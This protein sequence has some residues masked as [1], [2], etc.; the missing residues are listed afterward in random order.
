MKKLTQTLLS[1]TLSALGANSVYADQTS[2]VYGI[3]DRSS[4][5]FAL[6]HATVF[7]EPGK[8]IKDATLVIDNGL[9]ISVK[10]KG[11]VPA[12][13]TEVDLTSHLIY[14]G[15]I[16]PYSNY[17]FPKDKPKAPSADEG[18]K[19]TGDRKGGN[20]WNNAVHAEINWVDQF[21]PDTKTAKSF[22]KNGFTAVQT[23]K[24]D[25]IFQGQG[26]TVSLAKGLPNDLIYNSHA[27]HF[28]SFDKGSSKQEYPSSLMGSIALIRQTL[29]DSD[30]YE[31]AR[32]K[33]DNLNT[34]ELVEYNTALK[35]ISE[36][37]QTG[38]IFNADDYLSTMRADKLF[39]QFKVPTSFIADGHEYARISEIKKTNSTFIL[40]LNLPAKSDVSSYESQL[41]VSLGE[42]RHWE[43]APTNAAVLAKNKIPFAFTQHGL[44]K[45]DQFWDKI[46]TLVKHGL[47][48]KDALAALTTVPAKL[49]GIEQQAGQI[50]AGMFADLVV[51][52]GNLFEKGKIKSVWMQGK[53]TLFSPINSIS[54][55]GQYE[56]KM[57][58]KALSLKLNDKDG[59]VSGDFVDGE[60][61]A[62]IKV[63]SRN[64]N[65]VQFT[66]NLSELGMKGVN[67]FSLRLI[68]DKLV[69]NYVDQSAIRNN[70]SAIKKEI[71]SKDIKDKDSSRDK[72]VQTY[73]SQLTF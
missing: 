9:I 12:G 73:L 71:A 20:G 31:V 26:V 41:D 67:Q 14:P 13:A 63:S 4:N 21:K 62:A 27:S 57:G 68:D 64:D 43:R 11:K 46:K 25:G 45:S 28:G 61:K 23:A 6:T 49:A 44:K 7:V 48:E 69:G 40:P 50:R 47:S 36:I 17:V 19:Y 15:F 2:H 5:H 52:D 3:H 70:F 33:T 38:L 72:K 24:L 8:S 65:A 30:W 56:I 51:A 16:D 53:E 10:S 39:D 18:P 58:T 32:G 60:K 42:L 66:A 54:F 1:A 59:K 35:G 29:S 22:T 55:A 37:K 34:G